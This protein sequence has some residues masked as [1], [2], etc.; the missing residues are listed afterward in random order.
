MKTV[1][2]TQNKMSVLG[3]E[4]EKADARRHALEGE[5]KDLELRV[6]AMES[7]ICSSAQDEESVQSR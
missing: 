4:A 6:K 7:Q 5:K 3:E 1:S 2:A